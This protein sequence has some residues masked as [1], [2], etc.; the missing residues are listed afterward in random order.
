M[1]IPLVFVVQAH[2]LNVNL[3]FQQIGL[4][5]R[6][7]DSNQMVNPLGEV[8]LLWVINSTHKCSEY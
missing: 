5:K 8:S 3:T 1:A 2:Y 7:S 4:T 6:L